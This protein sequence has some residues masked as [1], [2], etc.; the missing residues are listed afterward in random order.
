MD[1]NAGNVFG[2]AVDLPLPG[3][4]AKQ[5]V[6]KKPD[7]RFRCAE[8]DVRGRE[9]YITLESDDGNAILQAAAKDYAIDVVAPTINF[10]DAGIE[11]YGGPFLGSVMGEDGKP[12]RVYRR[13]FKL[14]KSI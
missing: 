14:T 11:F 10:N 13:T 5:E 1:K 7:A 12:K 8:K 4:P 3:V 6:E 2:P 9:A